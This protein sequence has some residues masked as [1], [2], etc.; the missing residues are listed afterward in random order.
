MTCE[1]PKYSIEKEN[2]NF[3]NYAIRKIE[4]FYLKLKEK[5]E[6]QGDKVDSINDMEISSKVRSELLA[7]LDS[8]IEG[9]Q[10]KK[11]KD[12]N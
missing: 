8:E 9:T 11:S 10:I 2:T 7:R 5:R 1:K 3:F 4:E 12:K 6:S